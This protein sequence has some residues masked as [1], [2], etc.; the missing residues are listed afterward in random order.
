[1]IVNHI[2]YLNLANTSLKDFDANPDKSYFKKGDVVYVKN[3]AGNMVKGIIDITE[4]GTRG[5]HYRID[6]KIDNKDF[7]KFVQS[8][9]DGDIWIIAKRI[10]FNHHIDKMKFI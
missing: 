10:P 9:F 2:E 3:R 5:W 1:M 7:V 6:Y 8:I 4:L